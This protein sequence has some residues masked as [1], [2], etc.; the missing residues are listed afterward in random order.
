MQGGKCRFQ[1]TNYAWWCWGD[2][3]VLKRCWGAEKVLRCWDAEVLRVPNLHFSPCTEPNINEFFTK[4]FH[5]FRMTISQMNF[6]TLIHK[7]KSIFPKEKNMVIYFYES[8][9]RNSDKNRTSNSF[10]DV[11]STKKRI[12]KNFLRTIVFTSIKSRISQFFIL[13]VSNK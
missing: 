10:F 8:S 1:V 13:N 7:E 12:P 9:S 3:K 11:T 4:S 5:F 6:F 2:E